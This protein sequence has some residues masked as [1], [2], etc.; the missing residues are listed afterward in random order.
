MKRFLIVLLSFALLAFV[1]CKK[2]ESVYPAGGCPIPNQEGPT[3]QTISIYG[4]WVLQDAF[5]YMDNLETG[6]KIKYD[7]FGPNKTV[8]SLRFS[9]AILPIEVIEKGVTTWEFTAPNRIPGYG[10]FILN[11]DASELYGFYVTNNNWTIV[12]DPSITT[13]TDMNL[14]G[15]SRPLRVYLEDYSQQICKF[16]VQEAY[17]SVNGYNVHYFSELVF[18]KMP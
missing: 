15:S 1:S 5:L 11:N 8:S 10:K 9:G 13:A 18:K 12:E 4:K 2:Q 7:H 6:E 16:Y 17:E 14:G 3:Q